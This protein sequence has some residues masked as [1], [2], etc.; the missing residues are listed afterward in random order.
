M[1]TQLAQ[2]SWPYKASIVSLPRFRAQIM[3]ETVASTLQE[4]EIV[5]QIS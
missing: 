4:N 1:A 5:S 3:G 2:L